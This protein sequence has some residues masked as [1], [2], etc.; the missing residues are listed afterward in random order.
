M[1]LQK[2]EW[3]LEYLIIQRIRQEVIVQLAMEKLDE[4]RIAVGN[5][6]LAISKKKD[7]LLLSKVALLPSL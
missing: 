6:E 2:M 1:E 3:E 4:L 5:L 7:A